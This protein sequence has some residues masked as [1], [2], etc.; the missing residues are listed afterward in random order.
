MSATIEA[1]KDDEQH[2]PHWKRWL[3]VIVCVLV[4]V[5]TVL[6]DVYLVQKVR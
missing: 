6:V 1:M 3:V 5:A 4:V 2:F